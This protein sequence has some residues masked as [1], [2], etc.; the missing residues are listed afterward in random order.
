MRVPLGP[1]SLSLSLSLSRMS[2]WM[3]VMPSRGSL[4]ERSDL[5][6]IL[7]RSNRIVPSVS[8]VWGDTPT[9]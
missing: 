9:R 8:T 2:G 4:G 1:A 3:Y 7:Y 5:P 6:A